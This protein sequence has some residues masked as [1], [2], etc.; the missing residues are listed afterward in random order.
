L[1]SEAHLVTS[2]AA[3]WDMRQLTTLGKVLGAMGAKA[4][5]TTKLLGRLGRV[6]AKS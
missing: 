3:P 6:S 4:S 5:A 2:L 1:K